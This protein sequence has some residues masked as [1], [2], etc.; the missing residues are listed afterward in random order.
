[1]LNLSTVRC[2]CFRNELNHCLRL[3]RFAVQLPITVMAGQA[4]QRCAVPLALGRQNNRARL[5]A[6]H[7]DPLQV[8]HNGVLHDKKNTGVSADEVA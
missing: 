2:S 6:Q 5:I 1:M 7:D 4:A 8:I 3:N